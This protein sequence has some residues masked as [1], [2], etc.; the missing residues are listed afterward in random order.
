MTFGFPV[1]CGAS[2]GY[3]GGL[4]SHS[5]HTAEDCK[6]LE[7]FPQRGFLGFSRQEEDSCPCVKFLHRVNL[8]KGVPR[9]GRFGL[10]AADFILTLWRTYY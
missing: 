3:L 8:N 4:E 10:F 6:S 5:R 1:G 9:C 2:I 7:Y